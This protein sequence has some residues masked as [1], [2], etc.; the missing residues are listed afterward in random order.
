MD[1][2]PALYDES[3]LAKNEV[4]VY[5]ATY[6]DDMYVDFDLARETAS[7]I[8]GCKEFITNV[9][10][11]NALSSKSDEVMRQ[12]FALRDDVVD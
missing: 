9:M 7:K 11:H 1:D 6:I 3:Q 12:L 2:W 10:Y 4:P 5:A 8:K